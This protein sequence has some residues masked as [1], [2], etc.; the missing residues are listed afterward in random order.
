MKKLFLLFAYCLLPIAYCCSQDF[1]PPPQTINPNPT[2][3]TTP[4]PA[5]ATPP[6]W[7]WDRV[8]YGGGLGGGFSS[9]I[10][11]IN[12]NPQVGYKITERFSVGLG[13]TYMYFSEPGYIPDNIYGGDV[14]S[15][16]FLTKSLF[17]HAEFEELNGQ[18]N[19]YS[20]DRYFIN[21]VWVGGGIR[22][23][24]GNTSINIMI[25]F[26]LVDNQYSP[27]SNPEIMG[28]VGIGF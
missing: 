25:L 21:D 18:F 1:G 12:F 7:S 19:P 22:Q 16:F 6:F 9:G 15:R 28:G 4:P 17:L 14:F 3:P 5:N 11:F 26:N 13:G 27:F 23:R 2:N 8:Y 20:L 10:T 24:A